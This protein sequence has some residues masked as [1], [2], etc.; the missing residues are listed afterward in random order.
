VLVISVLGTTCSGPDP[1]SARGE[2][3]AGRK[4]DPTSAGKTFQ[5]GL[6]AGI[7]V[8]DKSDEVGWRVLSEYGAVLVARGNAAP[9]PLMIFPDGNAVDT[10]QASVKT[11]RTDFDGTLIELQTPAMTALIEARAEAKEAGLNISPRDTDSGRRSYEETVK[12]W[13]SRVNPGLTHW[14]QE[15][16]LGRED[17][18]R[19][20]ILSPREQIPEILR[21]E[22]EGLYFSK[23]FSKSILYSVAAPGSS[24]HLSMLAFDVRENE[25]PAVRAIL[26]RHGWFQTVSSDTPHFTFLG[27]TENQLPSLGLKKVT[28]AG[29]PFWIPRLE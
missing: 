12:L 10:W 16:R 26:A 21:L 29:R 3:N 8:P 7:V 4:V 27:V 24:Q 19:I 11:M 2:S 22:D 13:E 28:A 1:D 6:P 9:P 20:R 25:D 23:D 15:G 18:A 5:G 17:A 14:A